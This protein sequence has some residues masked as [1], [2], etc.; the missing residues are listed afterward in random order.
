MN[1]NSFIS[2]LVYFIFGFLISLVLMLILSVFNLEYT[3]IYFICIVCVSLILYY[4][5]KKNNKI[6]C[7]ILLGILCYIVIFV[8]IPLL[9]H[10]PNTFCS[11]TFGNGWHETV[12][13]KA[14]N[15]KEYICCP[16]NIKSKLKNND[17][18]IKECVRVN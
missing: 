6:L 9:N 14:D 16:K 8:F 5:F 17:D 12:V 3:A 15:T 4:Y 2:Y 13:I 7:S 18:K 1:N 11:A 10:R